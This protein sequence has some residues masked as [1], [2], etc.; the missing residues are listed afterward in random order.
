MPITPLPKDKGYMGDPARGASLG[1]TD[2]RGDP[3]E[4][5]KFYLVRLPLDSGGYDQGGVYWGVG[6]PLWRYE[7]ADL[8]YTPG[9]LALPSG[10]LRAASRA[11]A[12]AELRDLYPNCRFF[13]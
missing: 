8:V 7:A 10:F 11:A 13:R 1:R 3:D 4:Q 2:R 6:T 9:N 5:W 12:K